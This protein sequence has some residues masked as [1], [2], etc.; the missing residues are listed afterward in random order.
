M[1]TRLK[2]F[3]IVAGEFVAVTF[4]ILAANIE[5]ATKKPKP[6]PPSEPAAP[7]VV[8][9]EI[10]DL[11]FITRLR[12]EEFN[13]GEV[14][15]IISYITDNIGPR[16]TGSPNMKKAN[17]WSRDQFTKWGLV[18]SH[19]EPWGT[20]GRGWAY[21]FCEVRMVSPDYMQFLALPKAWTPGTNGPVRAEV[22]QLVATTSA[23]LDQYK[24]KLAGKIVLIGEP[25][26]PEP[27]EKPM[28]RRDDDAELAKIALF[29]IPGGGP[30]GPNPAMRQQ[31]M[32]RF[33]FQ[34]ELEKFL[35][36]EH[37]AAVLDLTRQPGQDGTI[38]VESGGSYDKG[39]T[40]AF[41]RIAISVEHYGRVV[42]LLNKK[43]PVEVEV[44][45]QT[46]FYDDDDKGYDTV[47]EIPGVDP[48]LKE[49]L[50]MLGGHLD[51]WHAGEGATDNGAGS[52]MVME[53]VRLLTKLH[54]QPRRT[55]RVALWS[56]E[57]E[58][59]LGSRG[60]VKNHFGGRPE[61]PPSKDENTPSFMRRPA[62]P[63]E[64]K[65]EQ[66]LVSAYFNLDN[67]TGKVRG[68]YLQENELVAPIFQKWMEPFRDL[69]MTTLT[70][71]N[72]GGTDHLSFVA[73]GIPGFQFIQDPMDYDTLT[74]HS[75]LDVYEHIR[76]DDMK[77]AA[78]IMACFV[79][80]AAMLDEMLPRKPIRPE[81][82]QPPKP[83]EGETPNAPRPVSSA[84][85]AS[86]GQPK[87]AQ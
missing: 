83:P 46:Q 81:E 50:V 62:G 17:E 43:V 55:V 32:Q 39:K 71:R 65:P 80:N 86:A 26:T 28:F 20:F 87:T 79:Y 60:Y 15:D 70:M 23:D 57:E 29:E 16:L 10:P 47:A 8:K 45:V 1:K 25:R 6:A 68:V 48:K 51:S 63:L 27:I 31:F 12:D 7:V 61:P 69:G 40:V 56:G 24:G 19:L 66:K 82:F 59:I 44:N 2:R 37:V 13:H 42:R 3:S 76:A 73:V 41:P 64:L 36:E 72:T 14:M 58:G 30:G 74:H 75:N 49:Q 35:T 84:T 85:P 5:A 52:A 77:Q 21:Q 18:N 38:F 22:V 4:L 34:R 54:A 33:R 78:V 11:E 53:A 9:P 67:G